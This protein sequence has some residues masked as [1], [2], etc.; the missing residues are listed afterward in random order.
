MTELNPIGEYYKLISQCGCGSGLTATWCKNERL[1]DVK[2]CDKCKPNMLYN[3]FDERYLQ[4]FDNWVDNLLA[5][6][7]PGW[8]WVWEDLLK[9][10]K[11]E[12]TKD[13]AEAKQKQKENKIL[14]LDPHDDKFYILIPKKYAET[15]L[16]HGKM[17]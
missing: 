13:L 1:V 5:E 3:I 2:A 12:R 7:N 9:E 10:K 15:V 17:T 4:C 11:C 6:T 14:I 16:L 8:E